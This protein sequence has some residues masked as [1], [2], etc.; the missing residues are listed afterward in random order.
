MGGHAFRSMETLLQSLARLIFQKNSTVLIIQTGQFAGRTDYPNAVGCICWPPFRPPP[1]LVASFLLVR[2]IAWVLLNKSPLVCPDRSAV[3]CCFSS[4]Q[5]S[6]F[7]S[8]SA[9][10]SRPLQKY[11]FQKIFL[12]NFLSL[13][14]GKERAKQPGEGVSRVKSKGEAVPRRG[15]AVHG[16]H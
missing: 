1:P 10:T 5:A 6:L 4:S 13:P 11:L 14:R 12:I 16:R 15:T 3:A 2:S 8:C 7:M 9:P